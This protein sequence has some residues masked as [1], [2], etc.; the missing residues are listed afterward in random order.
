MITT[1]ENENTTPKLPENLL[2]I[3][4]SLPEE[5][6]IFCDDHKTFAEKRIYLESIEYDRKKF[7]RR[8]V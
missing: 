7:R 6:Q 2:T 4:N 1:S 3:Y 8:G 5:Y